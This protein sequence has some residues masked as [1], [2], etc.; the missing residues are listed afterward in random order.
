[1]IHYESEKA[2]GRLKPLSVKIT[3]L[4]A[5]LK[6]VDCFSYDEDDMVNIPNLREMLDNLGIDYANLNKTAKTTAEL[7]VELNLR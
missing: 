5:E 7:E 3:T 2:L 6:G 4:N 1:M